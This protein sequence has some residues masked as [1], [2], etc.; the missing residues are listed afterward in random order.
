[1]LGAL[2]PF[3]KA[4]VGSN[5][6]SGF[7]PM[8]DF[9]DGPPSGGMGFN[10]QT[11][12]TLMDWKKVHQDDARV[13]EFDRT[14]GDL[15]APNFGH[16]QD[17]SA[18][19]SSNPPSPDKM[20]KYFDDLTALKSK[21]D[22]AP[23]VTD[24][25]STPVAPT[26]VSKDTTDPSIC[27]ISSDDTQAKVLSMNADVSQITA[28]VDPPAQKVLIPS[29]NFKP[30]MD[31]GSATASP[32]VFSASPQSPQFPAQA[33][34]KAGL[35][36]EQIEAMISHL[37]SS[38][39]RWVKTF[40]RKACPKMPSPNDDDGPSMSG[41]ERP[42]GGPP[43]MGG[44]MGA[45][46]PDA[47]TIMSKITASM[48]LNTGSPMG[49]PGKMPG[50]SKTP[51]KKGAGTPGDMPSSQPVDPKILAEMDVVEDQIQDAIDDWQDKCDA[52]AAKEKKQMM[53][54]QRGQ[55]GQMGQMQMAGNGQ[56]PGGG[57]QAGSLAWLFGGQGG[58]S[59]QFGGGM[60]GGMGGQ[61]Q[62]AGNYGS[63]FQNTGGLYS[64]SMS[65]YPQY[66]GS[67]SSNAPM[68]Y[69]GYARQYLRYY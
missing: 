53:S 62:I 22:A 1:V 26:T 36:D 65:L 61:G 47:D 31:N 45:G 51:P 46:T 21:V 38:G 5:S 49:A 41:G 10:P 2:A 8:G 54:Q 14:H 9:S 68:Y 37:D 57:A 44:G 7:P 11:I 12:Q 6:P 17:P 39:A 24:P 30:P 13:K 55:M 42:G 33:P 20:K 52:K 48:G 4:D 43:D 60:A 58:G 15:P 35:S 25:T 34:L 56:Q 40:E 66:I 63:P 3:S 64:N 27:H 23:L 69:N 18:T 29:Q 50:K 32:P 16:G 19:T 67:S 28:K 59:G